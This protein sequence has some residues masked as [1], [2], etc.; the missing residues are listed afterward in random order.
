MS[1]GFVILELGTDNADSITFKSVMTRRHAGKDLTPK[2]P[3]GVPIRGGVPIL[4]YLPYDAWTDKRIVEWFKKC[5]MTKPSVLYL[6][7]HHGGKTP[8]IYNSNYFGV[9]FVANGVKLSGKRV[10]GKNEVLISLPG[11]S[12]NLV[13][14]VIDACNCFSWFTAAGKNF[15]NVLTGKKGKPVVLGFKAK[16]PPTG[17]AK[18]HKKF[19][20]LIPPTFNF[21]TTFAAGSVAQNK[22]LGYWQAAG[23]KVGGTLGPKVAGINNRGFVLDINNKPVTL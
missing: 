12:D 1:N 22:L 21:A 4:S 13:L 18:L 20:E 17:T 23:K 19:L 15:Q 3:H 16:S 10:K 9:E 8:D 14:I 7:G 6:S 2:A 5:L 11:F